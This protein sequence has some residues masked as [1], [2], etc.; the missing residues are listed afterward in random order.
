[1]LPHI[2]INTELLSLMES[3]LSKP[4]I[5]RGRANGEETAADSQYPTAV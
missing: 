2:G 4:E 3:I 5:S 1:M